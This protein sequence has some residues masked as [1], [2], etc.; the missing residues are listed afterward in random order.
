VCPND[1]RISAVI[2]GMCQISLH[3]RGSLGMPFIDERGQKGVEQG[4]AGRAREKV[5]RS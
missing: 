5:S 2:K 3:S 4:E 1:K